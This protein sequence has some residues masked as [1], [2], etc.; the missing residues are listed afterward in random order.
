M[1]TTTYEYDD[2]DMDTSSSEDEPEFKRMK[3]M[4]P[5]TYIDQLRI[6][7]LRTADRNEVR[8]LQAQIALLDECTVCQEKMMG[9][10]EPT[11]VADPELTRSRDDGYAAQLSFFYN[12]PARDAV[13]KYT[14]ILR[15]IP[16][17]ICFRVCP[18]RHA[19]HYSC[20]MRWL[21]AKGV[22]VQNMMRQDYPCPVCRAEISPA[23]RTAL[24]YRDLEVQNEWQ[25]YRL[26]PDLQGGKRSPKKR[27]PKKSRK[28]SPRRLRR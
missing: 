13:M 18:N 8:R 9:C 1:D 10:Q 7:E 27:S 3:P 25:D 5:P 6:E 2:D 17:R 4:P 19:F 20:I 24:G 16:K 22:E 11:V 14:D 15:Y 26:F 12:F 21:E 28:R 23:V